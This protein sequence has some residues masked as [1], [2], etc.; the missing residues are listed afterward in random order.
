MNSSSCYSDKDIV[1]VAPCATITV[2]VNI[3]DD[4]HVVSVEIQLLGGNDIAEAAKSLALKNGTK[5]ITPQ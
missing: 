3:D 2:D 4:D 1:N 5:L